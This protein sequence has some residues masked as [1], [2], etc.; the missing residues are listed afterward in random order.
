MCEYASCISTGMVI[1]P[2]G[3]GS[4]KENTALDFASC[5]TSLST[6]HPCCIIHTHNNGQCFKCFIVLPGR[7]ARSIFLGYPNHFN[8]Q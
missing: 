5:C 6:P 4:L 8:F 1:Q 2:S 3:V 7:L